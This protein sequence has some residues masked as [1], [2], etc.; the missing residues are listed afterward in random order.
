MKRKISDIQFADAVNSSRTI[1]EIGRK[2]GYKSKGNHAY[3][4]KRILRQNLDFY[5][6]N[7]FVKD[8]AGR[9]IRQICSKE[10]LK[11]IVSQH[12]SRQGCLK[13]LG[14]KAAG[15]N[16][17]WID[18]WI[19]KYDL[20]T[21]HW[22]GQAHRKGKKDTFSPQANLAEIL[23]ENSDYLTTNSLR[24]KLLKNGILLN[25]CYICGLDPL[26]QKQPLTLQLDH[27]NGVH[28]DNRIENLRILCPNCHSQTGTYTGR[29]V[30]N[31]YKY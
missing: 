15:G 27:I 29:N 10:Q 12:Q 18:K 30:K 24:K 9:T 21:S 3:I 31:R 25:K 19:K 6:K 2:L 7:P 26:W 14:L 20:N 13:A 28:N 5:T 4:K 11:E 22:T 17:K 16:I 1:S 23:V 8:L